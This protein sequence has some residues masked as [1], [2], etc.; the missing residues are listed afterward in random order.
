LAAQLQKQNY[1]ITNKKA[2]KKEK[3]L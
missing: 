3:K 1:K 2:D